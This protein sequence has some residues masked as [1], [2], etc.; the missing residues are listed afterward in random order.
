[1][2]RFTTIFSL[3]ATSVM[4]QTGA[5]ALI[6]GTVTDDS[7]AAI[8]GV[9]VT[10]VQQQVVG[11]ARTGPPFTANAISGAAG[12]YQLDNLP[13]GKYTISGLTVRSD[14]RFRSESDWPS[15]AGR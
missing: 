3:F 4:A 1:M 14:Q 13:S 7:G 2:T 9:F 10:A 12:T 8:A 15:M 5:G 11:S 6:Q